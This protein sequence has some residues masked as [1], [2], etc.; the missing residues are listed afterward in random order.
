MT[1]RIPIPCTWSACDRE[2]MYACEV[3]ADGAIV[4]AVARCADHAHLPDVVHRAG[5]KRPPE[6]QVSARSNRAQNPN[7]LVSTV[8]W[9][10]GRPWSIDDRG[11]MVTDMRPGHRDTHPPLF[12]AAVLE[13]NDRVWNAEPKPGRC[14]EP[15]EFSSHPCI[16]PAGH[17]GRHAWSMAV[18]R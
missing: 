18:P 17:D 11:Y 14:G 16:R 9:S 1:T 13:H 5:I 10:V 2:A 7:A 6:L 4:S 3:R 12:R 8:G 15:R